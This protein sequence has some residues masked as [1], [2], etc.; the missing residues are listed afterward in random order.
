MAGAL[1]AI[2]RGGHLEDV[3]CELKM[4]GQKSESYWVPDDW[5]AEPSSQPDTATSRLLSN[6]GEINC[7]LV[8][9]TIS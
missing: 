2:L 4:M 9:T 5:E 6:E 1:A 3:S 8:Y 7:S